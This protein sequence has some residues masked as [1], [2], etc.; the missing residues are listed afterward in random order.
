LVCFGLLDWKD[1][2]KDLTTEDS[3]DT[4]NALEPLMAAA[5][6]WAHETTPGI[7]PI[8]AISFQS[9]L[10]DVTRFRGPHAV[11]AY[12]GLVP[13]EASSGERQRRGAIT[14]MG[15][16]YIR[17]VLVQASWTVWRSPRGSTALH[18]WV[19]RLADRRGKRVAIVA[20]ARRLARILFAMWRDG[21]DFQAARVSRVGAAA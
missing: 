4:E 7:G 1:V 14:K 15:P 5:D 6:A 9:T 12:L 13:R 8:T 18:A 20:L 2:E 3:E 17:A 11:S 19:H 21:C 16:T 10:D